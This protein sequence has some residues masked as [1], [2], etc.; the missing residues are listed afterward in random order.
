MRNSQFIPNTAFGWGYLDHDGSVE[1]FSNKPDDP[2]TD[3]APMFRQP[4]SFYIAEIFKIVDRQIRQN[5]V[6]L[7]TV[8]Y[9]ME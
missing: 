8:P 4:F 2:I 9:K 1:R 3:V 7:A 5:E 6:V